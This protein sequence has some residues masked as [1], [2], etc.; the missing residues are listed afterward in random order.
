MGL[1]NLLSSF[2]I[3]LAAASGA[4]D[5]TGIERERAER[6]HAIIERWHTCRETA[7]ELTPRRNPNRLRPP[8]VD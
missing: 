7:E 8:V 4:E 1:V 2:L 5:R 3:A 6:A